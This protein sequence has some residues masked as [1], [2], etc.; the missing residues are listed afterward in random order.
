M[1]LS[2]GREKENER[3]R[4]KRITEERKWWRENRHFCYQLTTSSNMKEL[5]K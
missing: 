3:K 4:K 5:K 1:D 2:Y